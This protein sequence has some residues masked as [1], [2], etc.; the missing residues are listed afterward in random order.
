MIL[1]LKNRL[2]SGPLLCRLQR[3]N[4]HKT[5]TWKFSLLLVPARRSHNNSSSKI[6]KMKLQ[7]I[8]VEMRLISGEISNKKWPRRSSERS[9]KKVRRA[10]K[11][12]IESKKKNLRNREDISALQSTIREMISDCF[13]FL[14]L[15]FF[16]SVFSTRPDPLLKG[17]YDFW[18]NVLGL[19]AH[20]KNNFNIKR[21]RKKGRKRWELEQMK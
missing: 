4:T 9:K 19:R 7:K 21:E 10:A 17:F 3:K 1:I 6:I 8:H 12:T 2:L 18:L 16:L 13:S 5:F 11:K 15:F 14:D 20:I